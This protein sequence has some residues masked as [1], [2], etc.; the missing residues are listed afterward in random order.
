MK[1]RG[2]LIV[3]SG[4]A[5][6]GK[7]T[8]LK[9]MM[10]AHEG[11]AYSVSATTRS[12]RPGEEHGK[13]YFFLSKEEFE[14]LIAEEKLLEHACYV[15]NYYGTPRDYVYEMT[16]QG[17]DVILEIDLQGAMAIREKE[18]SAILIFIMPPSGE[19]LKDRLTGRGTETPEVIAQRLDR[20]ASEAMAIDRYDYIV[21]N[22]D[23]DE[24]AERL[25]QL[26]RSQ[27]LRTAV[28]LPFIEKI[29]TEMSA[30]SQKGEK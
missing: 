14:N 27:R 10:A 6:V 28:N 30:F 3:L 9:K 18:P 29:Q 26:I 13:D 2:N 17:L 8:V 23:A 15:G 22:E 1:E 12:P 11:Y 7:G 20:A 16:E 5:G 25:H 24:C 21:V 4:F 19:V